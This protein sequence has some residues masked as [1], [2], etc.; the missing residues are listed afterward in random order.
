MN[1]LNLFGHED[2]CVKVYDPEK[3]ELI[4]TYN[5]YKEASSKL[6]LTYKVI[7]L[8]AKTKTR[9]FCQRFNK[10]IAIRVASSKK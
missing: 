7:S 3:K 5:T 4:A 10:E 2:V 9:R 8:A 1:P 6:G